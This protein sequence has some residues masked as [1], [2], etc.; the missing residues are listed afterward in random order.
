MIP[1]LQ[2]HDENVLWLLLRLPTRRLRHACSDPQRPSAQ[3]A[4]R[5]LLKHTRMLI[6]GC[7]AVG[8]VTGGAALTNRTGQPHL[9]E[10]GAE[11]ES[12]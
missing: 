7:E 8:V 9:G 10:Q 1:R 5:A 4:L 6:K 12:C 2:W 3:P 11:K